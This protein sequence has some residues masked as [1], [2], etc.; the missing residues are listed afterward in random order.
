MLLVICNNKTSHEIRVDN[1]GK[2][3]AVILEEAN[4]ADVHTVIATA[5]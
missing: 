2:L 5:S 1:V 3:L 4:Q